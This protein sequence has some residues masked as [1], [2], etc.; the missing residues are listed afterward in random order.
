[1]KRRE[2]MANTDERRQATNSRTGK[3]HVCVHI[4]THLLRN[5]I[6]SLLEI[7]D[8]EK[9]KKAARQKKRHI[10]PSEEQES[11]S[12]SEWKKT[13]WVTSLKH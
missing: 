2:G 1:M 10:L 12:E 4:Y 8:T 7:N 11:E 9:S 13:R 3:I 6:I 5:I